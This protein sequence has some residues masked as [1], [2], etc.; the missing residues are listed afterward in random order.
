M[1]LGFYFLQEKNETF[2]SQFYMENLLENLLF[3]TF[4]FFFLNLRHWR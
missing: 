2:D 1:F 4:F 3:P